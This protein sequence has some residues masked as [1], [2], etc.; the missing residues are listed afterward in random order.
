MG[1]N[2]LLRVTTVVCVC[3]GEVGVKLGGGGSLEL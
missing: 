3:L 1:G 2:F